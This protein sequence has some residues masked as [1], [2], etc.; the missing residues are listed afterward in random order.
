MRRVTIEVP[1]KRLRAELIAQA[2]DGRVVCFTC[3]NA[4]EALRKAGLQ[5][6]EISPHGKL[7]ANSWCTTGEVRR[8]FPQHYDATSGHLP[9]DMMLRLGYRMTKWLNESGVWLE[10]GVE[11]V[12]PSGSG[13]TVVSLKLANPHINFVARYDDGSPATHYDVDNPLNGLVRL[14]AKVELAAMA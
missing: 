10:D 2:C 1:A 11:Y 7:A 14:L 5:V 6:V 4:A 9:I 13:E 12:V 8:M 3:G